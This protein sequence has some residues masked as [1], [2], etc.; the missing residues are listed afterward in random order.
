MY[1]SAYLLSSSS[2]CGHIATAG[3][4][5]VQGGKTSHRVHF[6][7]Q[8]LQMLQTRVHAIRSA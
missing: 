4:H 3:L 2:G 7:I 8:L 5:I 1:M 6:S